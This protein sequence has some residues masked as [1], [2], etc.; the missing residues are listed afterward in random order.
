MIVAAPGAGKTTRVPPFLARERRVV[1]LQP[2]RVAARALARRIAEE[3]GWTVGEE[4]GWQVRFEKRFTHRT[5]LLVATEGVLTARMQDDPLLSDFEVVVLDEFHERSL[6]ADL[7]LAFACQA[8]QA[9]R[10]LAIVVMSATLD[11]APVA[12]FLGDCPVIEV[13]GA[14]HPVEVAYAPGLDAA[15]AVT[16]RTRSAAGH[17]LC[18][19]PGLSEIRRVEGFVAGRVAA[20]VLPLHGSLDAEAQD[21]ALRPCATRKL[22]L[23]TNIAETSLTVEGVTDVVDSG[24]HKIVRYDAA[25][26][27]DRLQ[28]ERISY[29][30]AEQRA[31]RAG[32]TGPGCVLRL[33]D[34]RERL[35]PQREPEIARVDLAR[36]VLEVLAWGGDP[37]RFSWF[38]APSPE[39]VEAAL[40]LLERLGAVHRGR[41]TTAGNTLRRL[42]LHPRLGALLLASGASPRAAAACARLAEGEGL[43]NLA[44]ATS[45]DLLV[46]ADEIG[47]ASAGVQRTARELLEQT[48]AFG[49]RVTN[50]DEETTLRRAVL[51]AY[52]DRVAKRREPRGNRLLLTS[53]QGARLARE[54]GVHE[55]EYLVAVDLAV[56]SAGGDPLVRLA[57]RIER[58]WL[59]PTHQDVEHRLAGGEVRAFERSWY[60][61]L[62]LSEN[63]VSADPEK[64]REIERAGRRAR[65]LSPASE[66]LLRRARF[67]GL[68]VDTEEWMDRLAGG[69][70]L[71]GELVRDIE[72][73]APETFLLPSGRR[74]S[75]EYGDEGTARISVKLQELFGLTDT[76]R[77]GPR[78][79]PLLL[80]LLAPNGRPVQT[81]RDLRSFWERTY[82]EVRRELRGRYPRHPWPEDPWTAPPTARPKRRR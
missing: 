45:S 11:T 59:A 55:G 6:N 38:D 65:G 32:R 27:F 46:L 34:A 13:P 9:R 63:P 66:K 82:P 62:L 24:L 30:S 15:E 14:R 5:R 64:V 43:Q 79:E 20:R 41:L 23:A 61:R 60:G 57:S 28:Q 69:S 68:T 16:S 48:R 67:A 81:T 76:P 10:E 31:G 26:S 39:K 74:T 19:L 36:P 40:H 42:P 51:A 21:E 4:V 29:D 44:P 3:Q 1:V 77:I 58:E 71:P 54:S 52:P 37:L 2:R 47:R 17:V 7:A 72:R 70:D 56:S 53:G 75:I 50:E 73:L 25:R 18:F 35:R 33:W 12:A 22:I 78:R 8:Q 80:V 49:A